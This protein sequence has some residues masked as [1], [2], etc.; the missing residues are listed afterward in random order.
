[1]NLLILA[2]VAREGCVLQQFWRRRVEADER[3]QGSMVVEME[4]DEVGMEVEGCSG[5]GDESGGGGSGDVMEDVAKKVVAGGV[6]VSSG[7]KRKGK[8]RAA[9]SVRKTNSA[10][11]HRHRDERRKQERHRSM[12]RMVLPGGGQG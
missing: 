5:G 1:M 9:G 10:S 11:A 8:T 3:A 2:E 6:G 4:V 12:W 7:G